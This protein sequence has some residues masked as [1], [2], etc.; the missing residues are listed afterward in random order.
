MR[1]ANTTARPTTT[2]PVDAEAPLLPLLT[3]ADVAKMLKVSTRTVRRLI[4]SGAIA[5]VTIGRS[6]RIR[7]EDLA[8]TM[9]RK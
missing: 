6:V 4:K 3:V 8:A 5:H 9:R 1:N 7:A 2:K